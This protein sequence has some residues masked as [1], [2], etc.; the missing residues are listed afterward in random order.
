MKTTNLEISKKL[1]EIG[2][3]K[4]SLYHWG[5]YNI[6]ENETK[7]E[8]RLNTMENLMKANTFYLSYDL[9]TIL[10]S[11]RA[12]GHISL[13]CG[14]GGGINFDDIVFVYFLENESLADTAGRLIIKLHEKGLINF[15]GENE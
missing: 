13:F 2:F 8:L 6:N 1:K 10:D 9:E 15:G 3:K 12:K 7:F 11:L 4:E 5:K 14:K